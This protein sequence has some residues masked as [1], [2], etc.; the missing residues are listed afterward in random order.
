[1]RAT[2]KLLKD[3]TVNYIVSQKRPPFSFSKSQKLTHF[4]IFDVLNPEK[5]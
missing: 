2:D 4:Y 5:I 1:M 3:D